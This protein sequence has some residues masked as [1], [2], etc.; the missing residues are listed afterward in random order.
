[1]VDSKFRDFYFCFC[2]FLIL[3]SLGF[4]QPASAQQPAAAPLSS[5]QIQEQFKNLQETNPQKSLEQASPCQTQ[6]I[7]KAIE[8]GDIAKAKECLQNKKPED[9]ATGTGA[10]SSKQPEE[11]SKELSRP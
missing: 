6:D 1:M 3:G 7:Q 5:S 2:F 10:A 8:R 11:P 4:V 9:S